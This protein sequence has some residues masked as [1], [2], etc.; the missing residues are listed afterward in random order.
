VTRQ[1]WAVGPGSVTGRGPRTG[2]GPGPAQTGSRL[3][4]R[5][6]ARTVAS[7]GRGRIPQPRP[8]PCIP[9][10][11]SAAPWSAPPLRFA[12]RSTA[13]RPRHLRGPRPPA[14]I[15]RTG[16]AGHRVEPVVHNGVDDPWSSR[17]A[18]RGAQPPCH[19]DGRSAGPRR[20][21]RGSTA[22]FTPRWRSLGGRRAVRSPGALRPTPDGARLGYA[23]A[24][25]VPR[26]AGMG[27]W[28]FGPAAVADRRAP[29]TFSGPCSINRKS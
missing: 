10:M 7:R 8:C 2:V 21:I 5:D 3:V 6:R 26:C 15:T 24:G 23:G 19:R 17:C 18:H 12:H 25:V 14:E 13:L 20:T 28:L 11:R 16:A 1:A 27:G 4:L 9:P 22:H 29:M